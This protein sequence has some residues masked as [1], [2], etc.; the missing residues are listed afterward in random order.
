MLASYVAGGGEMFFSPQSNIMSNE[1][2]VVLNAKPLL[3]CVRSSYFC[4]NLATHTPAAY[5]PPTGLTG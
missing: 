3:M 1:R 2:L 4:R 5:Q